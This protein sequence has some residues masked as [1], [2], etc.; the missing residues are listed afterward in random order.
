LRIQ[1]IEHIKQVLEIF[2]ENDLKINIE[3]CHF[4]QTEV[5]VLGHRV[6][7]EGLKP[8]EELRVR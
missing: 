7:T 8:I 2:K 4:M 5:D 1:N 6:T 3:K